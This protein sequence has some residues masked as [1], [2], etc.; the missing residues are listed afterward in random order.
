MTELTEYPNEVVTKALLRLV[1][2]PGPG[3]ARR[4]DHPRQRP[5]PQEAEQLRPGR[6]ALAGRGD[7]RGH[8]GRPGV[9]RADRQAV[10]LLRRRRHHRHAAASPSGSRRWRSA[11]WA[12]AVFARLKD[13]AIPTFAFV[14][15]AALGGGLEVA[16][17]CHYRTV[18]GGAAALG[19]P[20]VA[21]GLIPGWGGSQLLPN[22]IG[23]AGA[24]QV[25]LQNPLTQKVL[26]RSR[27]PRWASP[28]CCSSRPT[29]WSA[30]W[31][32]RP[33]WSAARSPSSGPRSTRTCGT[34]CCSSPSS[35]STSGCTARCRP[36][37]R[38]SNCSRWPRTRRSRRAPRPRP[39]RSPT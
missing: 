27:P 21:I 36:P 15:G 17:H 11:S 31:S 25:I 26:G 1:D 23:I 33:A 8:R 13:S 37:T 39:R 34:A 12:T 29:S 30:R 28:T 18:S 6:S 16:L 19:L 14:N 4:A 3:Q 2:V 20:E 7:H 10:H 38:R 9:H 5:R 22:L 35:S 32:G 24:A